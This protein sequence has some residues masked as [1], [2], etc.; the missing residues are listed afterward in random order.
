MEL[1]EEAKNRNKEAF[2]QLCP[3]KIQNAISKIYK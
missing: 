3:E 2:N 1:V